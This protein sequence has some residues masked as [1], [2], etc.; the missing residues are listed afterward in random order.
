MR[1]VTAARSRA[2]NASASTSSSARVMSGVNT[3]GS[4][5]CGSG[6][7]V[8]QPLD[9][10]VLQRVPLLEERGRVREVVGF[11][12]RDE[13]VARVASSRIAAAFADTAT[14]SG[15]KQPLTTTGPSA[16]PARSSIANAVS[17]TSLTGVSSASVTS[18]TWQRSGS[19]I[20]STTS[21]ACLR[22]GP[23]RTASSKPRADKEERDRVTGRGRVDD[24]EVG[25]ARF[26][27]RLHLA[28]HE[29]VLHARHRGRDDFERARRDEPL[30]DALHAV[31]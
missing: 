3:N 18:I 2:S 13:A 25:G 11:A 19:E 27:E 28:E 10:F 4:S 5:I 22:T 21:W 30:R 14:G 31:R 26:L 7:R 17:M 24:H 12:S 6:R 9:L 20:R 15:A 23:T 29:D 8:A 1:I 16:T